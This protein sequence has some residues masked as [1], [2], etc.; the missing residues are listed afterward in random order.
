MR[1]LT[2][3]IACAVLFL[4]FTSTSVGAVDCVG[5][6]VTLTAESGEQYV[7]SCTPNK[8][9]EQD[10]ADRPRKPIGDGT[11]RDEPPIPTQV[12]REP[13]VTTQSAQ[14]R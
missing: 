5:A 10:I 14:A 2:V 8:P 11:L 4:A 7:L 9:R 1:Q 13:L 3:A 12:S 6:H